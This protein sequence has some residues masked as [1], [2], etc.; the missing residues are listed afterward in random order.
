M[1][2]ATSDDDRYSAGRA[3]RPLLAAMTE[4]AQC[5]G[6]SPDEMEG[7]P[8]R[9][10]YR[11]AQAVYGDELPDFWRIWHEWQDPPDLSTMGEL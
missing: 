2:G 11:L 3:S 1:S 4:L 10:A 5:C 8:M 7:M 6:R 9:E